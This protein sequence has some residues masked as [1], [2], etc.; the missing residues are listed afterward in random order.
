MKEGLLRIAI[1]QMTSVLD[2]KENLKKINNLLS[3][4][5]EDFD[6]VFLPEC[7]YSFSN[8][9]R[10]TSYLVNYTNE[11][12][13]NIKE[14][15]L[16]YKKFFIGGSV[17]FEE[18]GKVLNRMINFDPK[19]I[20]INSYDK[21]NLFNC[22]LGDNNS[23]NEADIYTPGTVPSFCVINDFKIG[24]G[25]CFDLRFPNLLLRYYRE[26]VDLLTFSSAFTVP[27]GKAH[28]HTLLRARAI[29]G[30][31]YV[32]A[33]GQVGKNNN[34]VK[35][36]GHSLCVDPWGEVLSDQAKNESIK[37]VTLKKSIIKEIRNRISINLDDSW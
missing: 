28:W 17:A 19:G 22:R 21:I 2:Y 24:Y 26:K 4:T 36:Y 14:L 34:Q 20:V 9:K 31:T 10:P 27:T 7:F 3:L 29:E 12:F 25:I 35:T 33:S 1:I 16:K 15:V 11:H 32:V 37:I 6:V 23:I 30:Q 8:G 5:N 18:D 13:N